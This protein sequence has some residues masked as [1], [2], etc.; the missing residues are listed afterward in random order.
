[1]DNQIATDEIQAELNK[2]VDVVLKYAKK[3]N[4]SYILS[5]GRR[6][7]KDNVAVMD[8]WYENYSGDL[9]PMAQVLVKPGPIGECIA[10]GI[11]AELILKKTAH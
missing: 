2:F 6:T 4:L 8:S 5:T 10:K 7:D 3:H 1:M 9:P 11:M